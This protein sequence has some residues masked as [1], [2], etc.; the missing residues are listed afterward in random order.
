MDGIFNQLCIPWCVFFFHKYNWDILNIWKNE[1]L[2][3]ILG[4]HPGV[5]GFASC[6]DGNNLKP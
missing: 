3:N 2:C 4:G 1:K 5:C 6:E